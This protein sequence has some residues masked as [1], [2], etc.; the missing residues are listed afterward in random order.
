MLMSRRG[1][2]SMFP[3]LKAELLIGAV[4]AAST[5]IS[6][7]HAASFGHSRIVSGLGQP[8]QVEIP[9]T[10]LTEQE[11]ATLKA[12]PAPAQA[13]SDVG[14]TPPVPLESMRLVLLD[15]Y[16]PGVKVIQ[17]RSSQPFN[18][19][20]V[21]V[22]LDISS[23]AGQQRYQ[24]SLFAQA[25]TNAVVRPGVENARNPRPIDGRTAAV[26][27]SHP[28]AGAS[29]R[30]RPGDTLFS[31]AQRNAVQGVTVYQ[32]MMA[33]HRNNRGAFIEDNVNLVKAGA[34]LVMPD[35]DEL[36]AISDREAR[37][38]FLKHV[39]AFNRYRQR[40]KGAGVGALPA[41][42]AIIE[43]SAAEGGQQ[44]G[45]AAVAADAALSGGGD[46]LR[47]S[48]GRD[49]LVAS[50]DGGTSS[51]TAV[52]G[53]GAVAGANLIASNGTIASDAVAGKTPDASGSD[54]FAAGSTTAGAVGDAAIVT[55]PDVASVRD[56]DEQTAL[57]KGVEESQSRITELEDNLRHLNEALQKQ[58]HVAAEAAL[59]GA[60]SVTDAIKEV[61]GIGSGSDDGR[62]AS[63][64]EVGSGEG[65][66]AG[67]T[68]SAGV[69]SGTAGGES[70]S[71]AATAGEGLAAGTGA[72]AG[73]ATGTSAGTPGGGSA[74]A[75][76]GSSASGADAGSSVAGINVPLPGSG[77][78]ADSAGSTVREAGSAASPA[79]GKAEES[80]SW[81]QENLMAA[82]ISGLALLVII[83]AWILRRAAA[84]R[85]D[86]FESDSPIT[87]AMVREKLQGIDLELNPPQADATDRHSR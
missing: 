38:L 78:A 53:Q 11:I 36:T 83:V 86:A 6:G 15:G 12:V 23:S 62:T 5:G 81:W 7:A 16:R 87:D 25:D 50:G 61:I 67:Q 75:G 42:G 68:G 33:L 80:A 79:S 58:G 35:L 41:E 1:S 66:Q 77:T 26:A 69:Q 8:L 19:P 64:P 55:A 17:L 34:T 20:I 84:G 4:I 44:Q 76:S 21:D 72:S 27:G 57:R 14:M 31:I 2:G 70:A 39:E 60:R 3:A 29:I 43:E 56:P 46:R 24:V 82:A 51:Q 73:G 48:G 13:W 18:A 40:G 30:V 49:S 85:R 37:R 74:S 54:R 9:V 47:L 32:M 22:L 71:A 28:A 65:G 63:G 52:A 10:Q 45:V 59:E